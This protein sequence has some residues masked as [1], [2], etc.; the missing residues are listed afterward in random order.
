M[1]LPT[2][3]IAYSTREVC[4][5]LELVAKYKNIVES[6]ETG[7]SAWISKKQCWECQIT[8]EFNA[9][10]NGSNP[11]SSES[12]LNKYRHLASVANKE[13]ARLREDINMQKMGEAVM[14]PRRIS[15]A[16]ILIND[17]RNLGALEGLDGD[18]ESHVNTLESLDTSVASHEFVQTE[19]KHSI[20]EDSEQISPIYHV[21]TIVPD[22]QYNR[23]PVNTS[24]AITGLRKRIRE[25]SHATAGNHMNGY[26]LKK[27]KNDA[28]LSEVMLNNARAEGERKKIAFEKEQKYLEEKRKIEL[29]LLR[30]K[31]DF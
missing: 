31:L 16:S 26:L 12:L 30:R 11:R 3:P 23:Q 1:E 28:E 15:E 21:E 9:Q 24:K 25:R 2:R 6:K 22:H 13:L 19:Y 7:A 4:V 18:F 14:N 5:L 29:E 10:F 17:I 20:L 8:P 27:A